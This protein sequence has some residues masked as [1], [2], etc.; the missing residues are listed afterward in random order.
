VVRTPGRFFETARRVD[1]DLAR[2]SHEV[3]QSG[4]K[5]R[6]GRRW[7]LVRGVAGAF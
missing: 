1:E 5:P 4:E 7:N 6:A 2:I 3:F